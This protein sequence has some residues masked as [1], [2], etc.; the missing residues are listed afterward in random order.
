MDTGTTLTVSGVVGGLVNLTKV[1]AG[2]LTISTNNTYTGKSDVYASGVMSVASMNNG[3]VAAMKPAVAHGLSG[4]RG[5]FV[6]T[7]HDDIPAHHNFT[8]RRTVVRHLAP[9]FIDDPQFPRSY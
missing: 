1:G 8:N 6:I 5:I 7:L 4:G 2:T 3:G 9:F